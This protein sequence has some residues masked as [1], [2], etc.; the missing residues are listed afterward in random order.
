MGGTGD[1]G[2]LA[3][4]A[5][6]LGDEFTAVVY[7]RRGNSRSPPPAGWSETSVEEQAGDAAALLGVLGLAP[8]AVFGTSSGGVCALGLM[9]RH[10]GAVRGAILHEPSLYSA[11][12]RAQDF[13]SEVGAWDGLAPDVRER[14]IGYAGTF[15]G[16]ERAPFAA[17]RPDEAGLRAVA[18]PVQ[19]LVG[20]DSSRYFGEIAGWLAGRLGAQVRTVARTHTPY[21]DRPKE[22]ARTIRPFLRRVSR[23][24]D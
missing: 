14:M 23:R 4:V 1:A 24:E 10:P 13:L 6:A 7:D 9:L 17:W 3:P 5:E 19:L 21:V 20:E 22:L 11:L 12:R 15:F 18:I 2:H 16:L 8:A